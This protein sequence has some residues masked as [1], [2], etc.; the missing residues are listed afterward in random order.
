MFRE[1]AARMTR[2]RAATACESVGLVGRCRASSE[3]PWRHL[4]CC[5]RVQELFQKG[6]AADQ[7]NYITSE[8]NISLA[9]KKKKKKDIEHSTSQNTDASVARD[10]R[11]PCSNKTSSQPQPRSASPP[12]IS[13]FS[14]SLRAVVSAAVVPSSA[15]VR[16]RVQAAIGSR[17][18]PNLRRRGSASAHYPAAQCARSRARQ[19]QEQQLHCQVDCRHSPPPSS[20]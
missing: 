1:N 14:I 4:N 11:S 7:S 20:S 19:Q 5:G 10:M 12:G 17:A 15:P 16:I 2:E 9:F 18:N 13:D 8:Q 6:A 3:M